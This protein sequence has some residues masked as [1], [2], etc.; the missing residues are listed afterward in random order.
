MFF[1]KH[2]REKIEVNKKLLERN[3]LTVLKVRTLLGNIVMYN[4]KIK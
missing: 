4:H 2:F 3:A 1:N